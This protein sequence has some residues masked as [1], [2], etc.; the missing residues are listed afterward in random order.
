M[1]LPWNVETSQIG[2]YIV[3]YQHYLDFISAIRY[4][5]TQISL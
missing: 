1:L 3:Q 5:D 4:L 2:T